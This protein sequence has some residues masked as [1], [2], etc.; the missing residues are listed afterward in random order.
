MGAYAAAEEDGLALALRAA[1]GE[2]SGA[3]GSGFKGDGEDGA[4]AGALGCA[5]GVAVRTSGR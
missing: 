4:A 1:E 2:A 5:A 3:E